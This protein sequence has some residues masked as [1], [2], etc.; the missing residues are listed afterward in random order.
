MVD[1]I[2]LS[3]GIAIEQIEALQYNPNPKSR[4]LRTTPY[5]V[6]E[7]ALQNANSIIS[8]WQIYELEGELPHT[9]SLL[10]SDLSVEE[11]SGQSMS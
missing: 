9:I 8:P 3:G 7:L 4:T 5:T 2:D 11:P 6:E 10:D 1:F